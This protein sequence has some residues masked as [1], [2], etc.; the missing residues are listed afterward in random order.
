MTTDSNWTPA[1]TTDHR[2][3]AE[4]LLAESICNVNEVEMLARAQAH[5]TLAAAPLAHVYHVQPSRPA[6]VDSGVRDLLDAAR[7]V[8]ARAEYTGPE[9]PAVVARDAMERLV[10]CVQEA[11]EA[12]L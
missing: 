9:A 7:A 10:D 3:K 11:T 5:A 8:I 12:G 4:Q 6:A 1:H 2:A